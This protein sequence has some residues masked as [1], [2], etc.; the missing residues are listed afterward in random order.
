MDSFVSLAASAPLMVGRQYVSGDGG[1]ARETRTPTP[2]LACPF[3]DQAQNEWRLWKLI[4]EIWCSM[5]CVRLVTTG[6]SYTSIMHM[7]LVYDT[8]LTMHSI[9]VLLYL[10]FYRI[11]MQI[12]VQ[13]IF[14]T[15]FS[16]LTCYDTVSWYDTTLISL[17]INYG[18]TSAFCMHVVH[19]T[20][21]DTPTVSGLYIVS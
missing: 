16:R 19:D 10:L 12:C 4:K 18:V 20:S 15:N 7:I 5:H 9:I 17:L 14:V 8:T 11:S 2:P 1:Q 13:D 3:C 6:V 21:Y